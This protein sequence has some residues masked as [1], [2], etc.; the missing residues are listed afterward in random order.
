MKYPYIPEVSTIHSLDEWTGVFSPVNEATSEFSIGKFSDALNA[1]YEGVKR[2]KMDV[3]TF[4][5][6]LNP[7]ENE[8]SAVSILKKM[9]FNGTGKVE[10]MYGSEVKVFY[11]TTHVANIVLGNR[12]KIVV[13]RNLE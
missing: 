7:G 9:A 11:G 5:F 13:S 1:E 3:N 8:N 2:E 10:K 12:I 4:V 6:I